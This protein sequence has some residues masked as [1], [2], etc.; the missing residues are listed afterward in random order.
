MTINHVVIWIDHKE[1]HILYYDSSLNQLIK[2]QSNHPHVHHKANEIGSGK[3]L[4]DRKYFHSVI[5]AVAIVNEIL[6][7]GPGSAKIEFLKFVALHE[8]ILSKKIIG[9]ETCD[10]PTDP[11]IIAFAKKYFHRI[12]KLL[13]I[14]AE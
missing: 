7:M 1:A 5:C 10:H 13:P 2:S 11:Q 4:E 12:D 3:A 8:P 6:V 14:N 9:V